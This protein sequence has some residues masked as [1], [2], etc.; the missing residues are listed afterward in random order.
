MLMALSMKRANTVA[1]QLKTKVINKKRMVITAS[2]GAKTVT[3]DYNNRN[4]NRRV[5]L[6]IIQ[7]NT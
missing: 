1:G 2:S 5:E 7:D 3:G 6:T 4:R